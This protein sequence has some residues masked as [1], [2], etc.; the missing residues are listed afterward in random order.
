LYLLV[1]DQGFLNQSNVVWEVLNETD[2]DTQWVNSSFILYTPPSPTNFPTDFGDDSEALAKQL[3]AEEDRQYAKLVS[4]Q[5]EEFYSDH[6]LSTRPVSHSARPHKSHSPKYNQLP[7]PVP[8]THPPITR[9][10]PVP[11]RKK[12]VQPAQ[13]QEEDECIIL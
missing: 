1:T 10:Q 2:G 4:A 12:K 3:Q 9:S 5:D 7:A 13:Q 8:V 6:P 11:K